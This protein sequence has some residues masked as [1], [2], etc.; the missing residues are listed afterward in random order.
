MLGDVSRV[1]HDEIWAWYFRFSYAKVDLK[2]LPW[3][4]TWGSIAFTPVSEQL[5]TKVTL[6]FIQCDHSQP[7]SD[8]VS[9]RPSQGSVSSRLFVRSDDLVGS[10][11]QNFFFEKK[12]D[13]KKV[14]FFLRCAHSFWPQWRAWSVSDTG[15]A[16][17]I[18]VVVKTLQDNP[19]SITSNTVVPVS[20]RLYRPIVCLRGMYT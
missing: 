8:L 19:K 1:H 16:I 3:Q 9:T 12:F 4:P 13:S 6:A 5:S 11:K 15:N 17:N 10:W 14:E 18:T 2:C 7:A 20:G